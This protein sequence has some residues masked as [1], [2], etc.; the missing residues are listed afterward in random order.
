MPV[1]SMFDYSGNMC[2]PWAFHGHTCYALDLAQDRERVEEYSSGGKV[3]FLKADLNDNSE[4]LYII[5]K[6]SPYIL[7]GFPPCTHL[8]VLGAKH[9]AEKFIANVNFQ[10][11]AV[12]LCR[13]VEL[14][15]D[16]VSCPWFVENPVS[17]LA[18]LWRTPDY[19]FDPRDYGGYLGD[20]DRH[21]R[22]P[23]YIPP[24][25]AY[26]KRTCLWTGNGFVMPKFKPVM[27]RVHVDSQGNTGSLAFAKL[28][29]KSD[30]TKTIRSETPRGFAWASWEANKS[31]RVTG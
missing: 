12:D 22:Y 27:A 14:V 11:E 8:A 18:T 16:T 2:V 6:L 3:I 21:P 9:F 1:V 19:Y 5:C 29:G 10:D 25:D 26:T 17:R 20:C 24:R 30:K 31:A 15:G 23:E 13:T 4:L 7:F 28:G